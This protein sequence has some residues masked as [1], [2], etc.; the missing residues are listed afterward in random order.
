MIHRIILFCV[1][2]LFPSLEIDAQLTKKINAVI[3][4]D[5]FLCILETIDFYPDSTL[6]SWKLKSKSRTSRFRLS[7]HASIKEI[8]SGIKHKQINTF[9]DIQKTIRFNKRYEIKEFKTCFPAIND[10]SL[11]SI[12]LSPTIYID[13]LKLKSENFFYDVHRFRVPIYNHLPLNTR[14]DSIRYS[15]ELYKEGVNFFKTG[16]FH[17]SIISFEKSLAINRQLRTWNEYFHLG[18]GFNEEMWI[19]NCYYK[20]GKIKEAQKYSRTYY[21]E[22]FDKRIREK[23]DSLSII[24][25]TVYNQ[26]KLNVLKEICILDSL[27]IGG[28]SF[29]YAE[30]LYD[31]GCQYSI[32]H[33]FQNAKQVLGKAKN[34]IAEKYKEKN[35]LMSFIYKQFANISYNENDI[36]SAIR[37]MKKSL[38]EEK[39]TIRI[40]D[41]SSI[42]SDYGILAN[43]YSRAGDWNNALDLMA[44]RVGYWYSMYKNNPKKVLAPL[45]PWM[46]FYD[47]RRA[48]SDALSDYATILLRAGLPKKALRTYKESLN[49]RGRDIDWPEYYNLGDYYFGILDFDKALF[50][51]D[52][53]GK[54]YLSDI[55]CHSKHDI[56]YLNIQNS[57]ASAY[58]SKGDMENA[59]TIQKGIVKRDSLFGKWEAGYDDYADYISNLARFYNL[60]QQYDSAIV[61]EEKSLEMK[62]I[63]RPTDYNLAYSYMN[64]GYSYAGKNEW[65]KALKYSLQAYNIY[66]RNEDKKFHLR[67]LYDLS[68][69]YFHLYKYANLEKCIYKMMDV[70][71]N[72]LFSTL[73]DLTYDERSKYVEKYSDLMNQTIPMYAY[74]THSDP[75]IKATY[76]ASLIMKGALLNS[77]NS[78]KRVIEE[79][80]N[81]ALKDL[82]AELKADRYILA[83][84]L[85]KDSLYRKLNTDSLQKVIY[86]LEDS[87]IVKCKEY[88]D[89][90]QSMKLKWNDIQNHLHSEDVAIEFL[91]FPVNNDSIVYTALLLRKGSESPKMI[92]LFEEKQLTGFPDSLHYQS[93][94]MTDLVWKPLQAEFEGIKNIYFSPS[95]ALY[96]IGIEYLP[97]MENYNI[98]RL[99]STRE[100]VTDLKT[101][102][103]KRAV[104]YGGLNYDAEFDKS[105][106][107][108]SLAMLDEAFIERPKV[109]GM[110]LRG[111]KEFL[112]HTKEEV[113]IIGNEL[114][115]ANWECVLDTAAMGTE[116]S[117]KALSGK[118]VGCLHISTHGFYYNKEYADNARYKFMLIDNNMISAEDK[119]LTR[120]G[121]VM[122]RA[123]HILEDKVLPDNVEDGILTAKE[124]ADVD[125]RGLDLVV[126][127]ACQT[128]LGDI[129]QGEG[130]FGL[131]RGFK[132]AGANSILMSLWEVDDKATQIMMTQFYRNLLSGQSKRQSLL[133]AQKNLREYRNANGEQ[134]YNSP[135]YWAAFILLDAK[136]N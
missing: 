76:N 103:K 55:D 62:R 81:D 32:M 30:S 111:G 74:Y 37:Y 97:G 83:K 4:D 109:R 67:S 25:D 68:K 64:L 89:I 48:Y 95:G 127:S 58:C 43:Y 44:K 52:K 22:P 8:E 114:N 26:S 46:S 50:Y 51:Y 59:M 132:K 38:L 113:D 108:R 56:A 27:Y 87:L 16:H 39:D 63:Y 91:S 12:Y 99:S 13:S 118:N 42:S 20:L 116:E 3:E 69:C 101:G 124:I 90:T 126:L 14:T 120:S 29:R 92:T 122:S 136:D 121:L 7:E 70:A 28:A 100:L 41:D 2:A 40:I 78:V 115:N 84:S 35:W 9:K 49:V 33:D 82:W 93:K 133:N 1:I 10:T 6:I 18:G 19:A 17:L 73:Q 107:D 23:A 130:V 123:N 135:K 88:G 65:G 112:K 24:S 77:E 125:L 71:G 47:S 60:D 80:K 21:V 57:L 129:A 11:I 36:V 104:L 61:Y 45:G 15:E 128:G 79:S 110:G 98:Y 94:E 34:I 5:K 85:E 31:L 119:A 102:I 75:I 96:N 131:Q 134:C 105:V 106:T 86:R 66:N 72:A 53:A 117:F 54:V